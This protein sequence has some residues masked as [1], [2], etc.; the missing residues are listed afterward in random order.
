MKSTVPF[1]N[2]FFRNDRSSALPHCR[3][4]VRILVIYLVFPLSVVVSRGLQGP[5]SLPSVAFDLGKI[6]GTTAPGFG[7]RLFSLHDLMSRFNLRI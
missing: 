4:I 3:S 5:L 6:P 2:L 7:L 1:P